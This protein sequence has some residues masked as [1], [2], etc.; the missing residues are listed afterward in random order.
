MTPVMLVNSNPLLIFICQ[1]I[2]WHC[3][4]IEPKV[5]SAQVMIVVCLRLNA[6]SQPATSVSGILKRIILY[7]LFT[8]PLEN[9]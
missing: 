6:A 2:P 8:T 1:N 3:L 9:G 5:G 4:V 7:G